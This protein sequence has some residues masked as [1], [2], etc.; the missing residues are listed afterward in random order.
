MDTDSQDTQLLRARELV[1]EHN[2][3]EVSLDEQDPSSL[4]TWGWTASDQVSIMKVRAFDIKVSMSFL[5]GG[6]IIGRWSYAVI[7]T[8]LHWLFLLVDFDIWHLCRCL[9]IFI[10]FSWESSQSCAKTSIGQQKRVNY[11][12]NI[13][14]NT[15]K[16]KNLF[17]IYHIHVSHGK[18]CVYLPLKEMRRYPGMPF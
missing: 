12:S 5:G 3:A 2:L 4:W 15:K 8:W 17:I 16:I 6:F 1:S 7:Y 14:V 9:N 11:F 13:D 10:L 18:K